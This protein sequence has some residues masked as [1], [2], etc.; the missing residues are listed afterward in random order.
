MI[1]NEPPLGRVCDIDRDII[2]NISHVRKKQLCVFNTGFCVSGWHS[3]MRMNAA[4]VPAATSIRGLTG[5]AV[6]VSLVLF[7]SVVEWSGSGGR[8]K[9]TEWFVQYI[10]VEPQH[11]TP[12]F[13]R[14]YSQSDVKCRNFALVVACI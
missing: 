12:C 13:Y 8:K 5:S 3:T 11:V 7:D 4:V 9:T 10:F 2:T 6:A 1:G 14:T